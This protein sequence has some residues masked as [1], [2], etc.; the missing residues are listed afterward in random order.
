MNKKK[1]AISLLGG[2]LLIFWGVKTLNAQD[3]NIVVNNIAS[4]RSP[5]NHATSKARR[6]IVQMKQ[7]PNTSSMESVETS[8]QEANV[9]GV[10]VPGSNSIVYEVADVNAALIQARANPN[11]ASARVE[12][13]VF[14]DK[15]PND[16]NFSFQWALPNM[17]V[18][19][20][21][22]GAWELIDDLPNSTKEV[23]VAVV[24]TGVDKTHPDLAGKF[25]P[26]VAS[27]W[28]DC[29]QNPCQTNSS[30]DG[31][32]HGTH[33]AGI[34]GAVT[35][36]AKGV[37]GV[38]HSVKLMSVRILNAQGVGR[39]AD[40]LRGVRYAADNGADVINMSWGA[41]EPE[42]SS[43]DIAD[44]QQ[45]MNYAWNQGAILVAAA[46]NC[47][48][49]CNIAPD[50]GT[51]TP[52]PVPTIVNNPKVYPA[53]SNHVISVA[54]LEKDNTIAP[55]SEFGDWVDIAAPGGMFNCEDPDNCTRDEASFG[56]LSTYP[57]NLTN[58][59]EKY[60]FMIGTS[61]A[62]PQV[63]GVAALLIAAQS[64]ITKQDIEKYLFDFADKDVAG[65]GSQFAE[66]GVNA[67]TS[68]YALLNDDAAAPSGE[69]NI[70]G[71]GGPTNTPAPTGQNV[72][73]TPYPTGAVCAKSCDQFVDNYSGKG[74]NKGDYNCSGGVTKRDYNVFKNQFGNIPNRN[75]KKNDNGDCK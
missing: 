62:T 12:P 51:G 71:N 75:N 59:E 28:V 39:F 61:M 47:G 49:G 68:V 52:T 69:C 33:V 42:M 40:A 14:A 2:F 35:E 41:T 13:L 38:G 30:S 9:V 46:G 54:A 48:S 50:V 70:G 43:D 3:Q 21:G 10:L 5:R 11:V 66:G 45:A 24:D 27:D 37:A 29:S 74:R 32:G 67:C 4:S 6:I 23:K 53:Y 57:T 44:I 72:T 15:V 26:Y 18:A 36:N 60:A 7:A 1:L 22:K 8:V 73:P 55:Y 16:E 19:G 65:T 25:T 56:I 34:I 64:D 63:S 58:G 17:Q 20:N 31:A